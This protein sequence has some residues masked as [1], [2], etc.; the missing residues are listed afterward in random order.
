[1][2]LKLCRTWSVPLAV[3]TL[4]TVPTFGSRPNCRPIEAAVTALQQP[5]GWSYTVSAVRL[6][7]ETC[8][9]WS[10]FVWRADGGG[11]HKCEQDAETRVW[12]ERGPN[13]AS[14]KCARDPPESPLAERAAAGALPSLGDSGAG[15]MTAM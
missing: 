2:I 5:S 3:V 10:G 11:Q 8:T 9:G 1:M 14:S 4:K 12:D 6:G 15:S 7:A 13:L